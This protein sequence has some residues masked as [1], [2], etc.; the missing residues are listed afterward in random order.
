MDYTEVIVGKKNHIATITLNRPE[1]LNKFTERLSL[2][3]NEAL[4]QLDNDSETRVIV[5]KGS[6]KAF[7]AGI[8]LNELRNKTPIEVHHAV[9]LMERMTLTI[10]EIRKPVIVS[11]HKVAVANGIGV[12][13]SADLAIATDDTKFGATAVKV[14]LFCMGPAIPLARCVGRKKALEMLLTGDLIDSA[15]A[16]RIGLMNK[17]VSA[18]NLENSTM[19]LA[20]K[21]SAFSPLAVQMGKRS[22]YKTVDLNSRSAFEIA[23]YDFSLLA[24]TE[25]GQKGSTAFLENANPNGNL[26][27]PQKVSVVYRPRSRDFD[28]DVRIYIVEIILAG[29]FC[30]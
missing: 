1:K 30:L 28:I 16:L 20:E 19:K 15:E 8:D 13:A 29:L 24:S 6:G 2:E 7:C 4:L 18:E 22:F 21:I 25:D 10:A 17:V 11:V 27:N 14:G 5:I 3:L 23:N 12:V 26:S 9:T